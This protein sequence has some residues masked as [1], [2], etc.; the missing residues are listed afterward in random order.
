L[1]AAFNLSAGSATVAL[2]GLIAG[3]SISG[4]GLPEGSLADGN[5]QLPGHGVAF[6]EVMRSQQ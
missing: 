2:P 5:L 1:L 4:H 3:R 6:I